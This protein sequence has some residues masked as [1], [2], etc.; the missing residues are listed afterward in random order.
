MALALIPQPKKMKTGRGMFRIPAAGTIGISD[1]DLYSVAEQAR[2]LFARHNINVVLPGI[3][4]A[5]VIR[6]VTDVKTGGYRLMISSRGVIL[7]ADSVAAAFHGLQTLEQISWQSRSGTLPCLNIDDWPDFADRGLYYDVSR[8]R[9][10]KLEQLLQMVDTL[11]QYKINQLQ[12]YIEHTFLFRGHPDIGKGASPLTAEDILILDRH[13]CERHV[14]LVPSLASF[15]HLATVLKHPRYHHL[16]ETEPRCSLAPANPGTYTFLDSLFA[17]FLPLFS[18]KRFNVCCDEVGDLGNGQS[19]ELCRRKGKGEVYLGHLV[20]LNQ[21]ARKYGKQIMFWGDI[22]RHYPELISKIP[23]DVTVL[24][25]AYDYNSNFEAIEDFKKA[26]LPF[27]ACPGTS[28]WT[29]LFPRLPEARANIAGFA[30]A[31]KKFG[32]RGLLNTDWGDGG[33][34]NFMENSWLGYLF[35]AEQAWNT[36]ANQQDFNERFVRL[37]LR[38]ERKELVRALTALGDISHLNFSACGVHQ[39]AWLHLFFAPAYELLFHKATPVVAAQSRNNRIFKAP[40]FI[41]AKL[42]RETLARL[43]KVRRVLVARRP[44]EDPNGVLP[45]WIFAVDATA[46]AAR[47]LTVLAPGGRDTPAA[48][49]ALKNEMMSLKTRF[50]RLWMARNRRSEITITLARYDLAIRTMNR[51]TPPLSPA[52][53]EP[54]R[55]PFLPVWQVSQVVPR[56]QGVEHATAVSLTDQLK[57]RIFTSGLKTDASGFVNL[58]EL[59]GDTDGLAYL[60][61][62]IQVKEDGLWTLSVGHDGGVRVFVDGKAV[63]CQPQRENPAQQFRSRGDVMLTKG[64]HE[65]VI[66][67]DLDH[68]QGWGCYVCFEVPEKDRIPL[69]KG[70]FS[71]VIKYP[72]RNQLMQHPL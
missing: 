70:H 29:T 66:A 28:S 21:L 49:Q 6:R 64:E 17:E 16:A 55:S 10:P 57:W 27:F 33:H 26:G 50:E 48:R 69:R 25:W 20:K 32:A 12:L 65:I 35:G 44:G 14:E 45:Y 41:D 23:K 3:T 8:G 60:A 7:E 71:E 40:L 22:I 56:K 58:H 61:N 38:S 37:F 31:G 34:F 18:S 53:V 68:G 9:V 72:A 51:S 30:A 42:G 1:G 54:W 52:R 59:Y 67:M 24:D 15:G 19:A 39:S 5:L 62:R 2:C 4:D 13:C 36:G 63:L 43:A 46:H 47:K 11:A